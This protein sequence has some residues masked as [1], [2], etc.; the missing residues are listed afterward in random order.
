MRTYRIAAIPGD[1]IGT[2][3]IAAGMEALAAC[4]DRDGG[5]A[6]AFDHVDW[7]TERY[8]RTGAFM[9]ADG[10][11][12]IRGHDAILF[13]SAGAPDVPRLMLLGHNPGCEEVVLHLSGDEIPMTTAN[14]ARLVA[15][16]RPW[17]ELVARPCQ[18]K[19]DGV[20]RPK[21]L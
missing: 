17:A 11:D 20:V 4:A 16:A 13:G 18:F 8:K 1:G 3:V 12:Q 6:L 19:L 7:G 2:E 9:P 15:P 14:V 5:F 21:E 10:L